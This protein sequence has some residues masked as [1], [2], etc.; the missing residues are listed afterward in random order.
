MFALGLEL[1][2]DFELRTNTQRSAEGVQGQA[3][4][5]PGYTK[6]AKDG[7]E[8]D[9]RE[10]ILRKRQWGVGLCP[11]AI[12]PSY[13]PLSTQF[14]RVAFLEGLRVGSGTNRLLWVI[15]LCSLFGNIQ[16]RAR[17]W[18]SSQQPLRTELPSTSTQLTPLTPA[19]THPPHALAKYT[20]EP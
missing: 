20:K 6:D 1:R 16:I 4:P 19:N 15:L 18:A 3:G 17:R 5:F 11:F 12:F 2:M 9:K 8:D 10:A 14:A 7:A 13:A